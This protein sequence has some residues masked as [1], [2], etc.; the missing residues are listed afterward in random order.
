MRRGHR[1]A[2]LIP[3]LNERD[4]LPSVLARLPEWV[5]RVIVVDNGSTDGTDEVALACGAELVRAPRRGYGTAVQAGMHRLTADPPDVLVILDADDADDPEHMHR[6]VDP[7]VTDR[8]ELVQIDR[9]QH[10]EPGSLTLPQRFGNW[11][12]TELIARTVG[13]R[14]H[15][16]GPF[17]AVRFADLVALRMEDPTWGWN[18]EMQMKAAHAG[19]RV[20][21][22]PLPYH[23]RTK[24]ESKISGSLSGAARAGVR[25]LAAVHRYRHP[26]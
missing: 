6:L 5:D 2:V 10:A 20:L 15:D 19:L 14:T 23:A 18:V 4:S 13:L 17:R 12:A 16:M 7:I 3:A 25:I 1:V 26:H 24:G 9:T 22:V 8:A 21:E 11:L